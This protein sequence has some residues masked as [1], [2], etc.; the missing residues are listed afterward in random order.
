M[1]KKVKREKREQV[2]FIPQ[3]PLKAGR[4]SLG[5]GETSILWTQIEILFNVSLDNIISESRL[6][7]T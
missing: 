1:S 7:T 6:L 4:P 2:Q 5:G 3:P